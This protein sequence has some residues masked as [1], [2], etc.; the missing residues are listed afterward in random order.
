V[1]DQTRRDVP[2]RDALAEIREMSL[3]INEVGQDTTFQL[4]ALTRAFVSEPS[5]KLELYSA[6]KERV[7]KYSETSIRRTQYS[8]E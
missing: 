1:S 8:R 5:K 3:Q 6:L 2:I 4:G 7:E